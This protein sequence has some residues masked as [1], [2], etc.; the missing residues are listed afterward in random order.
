MNKIGYGIFELSWQNSEEFRVD[1]TNFFVENNI[2]DKE[3]LQTKFDESKPHI[4]ALYDNND[5]GNNENDTKLDETDV[6]T[7]NDDGTVLPTENDQS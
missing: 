5:S 2:F 1:L 4:V 3:F 6:V 7:Q